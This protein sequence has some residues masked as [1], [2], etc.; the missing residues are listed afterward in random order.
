MGL[1]EHYGNWVFT[2]MLWLFIGSEILAETSTKSIC[3]FLVNI[4]WKNNNE[5][6]RSESRGADTDSNDCSRSS[7]GPVGN[8]GVLSPV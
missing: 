4:I 6:G 7:P 5:L 8:I 2:L 3:R 1:A